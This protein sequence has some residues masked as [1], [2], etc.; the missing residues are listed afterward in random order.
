MLRG[1]FTQMEVSMN[2]KQKTLYSSLFTSPLTFPL[3]WAVALRCVRVQ[4]LAKLLQVKAGTISDY[5][6]NQLKAIGRNDLN[7]A[8]AVRY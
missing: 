3:D 7:D 5:F 1:P 2:L 8:A 6:F 4:M